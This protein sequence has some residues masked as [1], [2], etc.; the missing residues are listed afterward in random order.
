MTDQQ[1]ERKGVYLSD[2]QLK[3][4]LDVAK[5]F[6]RSG[7]GAQTGD[8]HQDLNF[9]YDGTPCRVNVRVVTLAHSTVVQLW[10][11]EGTLTDWDESM[12][13]KE[14]NRFASVSVGMSFE[15]RSNFDGVLL[16]LS[17]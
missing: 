8:K 13:L 4:V 15:A 17:Q 1:E 12:V 11:Q 9:D 16:L 14:L 10:L 7:E 3:Q 6:L 5:T 2:S